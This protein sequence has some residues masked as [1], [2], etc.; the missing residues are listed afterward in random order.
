MRLLSEREVPQTPRDHV[1][2][3]S[4]LNAAIFALGCGGGCVA[5][6]FFHWPPRRA[7]YYISAVILALLF[8][9]RGYIIP[10]FH[11]SN[12]LVRIG[13]EGLFIHFRSYLNDQMAADD[14]TV[15]FL[16]YPEIQSG[17]RVREHM[18]TR[19][20]D[21]AVVT[22]IRRYVE[23]ELAI[24]PA[25]LL[26]ALGAESSRPALLQ[27]RWYGSSSTVYR[28]YPV[29]MEVPPF[30]RIEWRAVPRPAVFLDAVRSRFTIAPPVVVSEDFVAL[31]GLP[32]EQQ[33]KRLLDLDRRGETIA[34]VYMARRLF[35]L[36][37]TQATDFVDKLREGTQQ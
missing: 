30:L 28:D 15:L 9:L 23:L 4:R 8:L 27:K 13:D 1:F 20:M 14:P 24:D 16:P 5:M 7:P 21:G 33:E 17:R 12:W 29:R 18:R 25:P 19:D 37:L 31:E 36:D 22:Q 3:A 34:A 2:R 32:R 11:P 10:R 6:V 35:G 26:A